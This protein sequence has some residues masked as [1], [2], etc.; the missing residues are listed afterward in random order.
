MSG[1][2]TYWLDADV[3]IQASRGPYKRVP[4]WWSFLAKQVELGIAKSP[5]IVYDEIAKGRDDLAEWCA[6]R[7]EKGL[8]VHPSREIQE[9]CMGKIADYVY[10]TYKSH[11]SAEFLKG[12]DAWVIAHAM[13]TKGVVVTMESLRK[14]KSK[15]KLPTI[16]KVF[17][18][19]YIN[20]YEMNDKLGFQSGAK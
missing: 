1:R 2:I 18:I 19:T 14:M 6:L 5:K 17:D 3:Y 13:P 10:K 15:I 12:G 11:Q 8:C 7:K 4:Q 16:C 9:E 20:T